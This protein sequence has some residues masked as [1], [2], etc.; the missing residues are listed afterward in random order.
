LRIPERVIPAQAG[1]QFSFA[2]RALDSGFRRNDE[3]GLLPV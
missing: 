1:I 3:D 2:L